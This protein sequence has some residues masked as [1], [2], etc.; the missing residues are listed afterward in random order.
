MKQNQKQARRA[1]RSAAS[2]AVKPESDVTAPPA[3]ETAIV[4]AGPAQALKR[5]EPGYMEPELFE[6]VKDWTPSQLRQH[7]AKL[8]RWARQMR[9]RADAF[10][11]RTIAKIEPVLNAALN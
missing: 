5:P 7:A 2:S 8:A 9:K 6:M 11:K 4:H 3:G 10:P 1:K